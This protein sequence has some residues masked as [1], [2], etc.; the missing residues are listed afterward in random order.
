MTNRMAA[1]ANVGIKSG[2]NVGELRGVLD[3]AIAGL[4]E[5]Y[6]RPVVLCYMEGKTVEEAARLLGCPRAPWR[7]AWCGPKSSYGAG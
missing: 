6:R 5:A 4:P 2:T 7:R 1:L 3:E